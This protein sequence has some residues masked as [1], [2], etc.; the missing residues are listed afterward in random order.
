[1]RA[2]GTSWEFKQLDFKADAV[3]CRNAFG[4]K[5]LSPCWGSFVLDLTTHGY[6]RFAARNRLFGDR[7]GDVSIFWRH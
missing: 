3:Q 1:M 4:Q 5:G 6:R 7:E 2:E